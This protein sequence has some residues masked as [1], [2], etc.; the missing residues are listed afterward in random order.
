MIELADAL[1]DDI[2]Q[3]LLVGNVFEGF[4]YK[5]TCHKWW[6]GIFE[7]MER[8]AEERLAKMKE[9]QACS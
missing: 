5:M 4:F 8:K 3:H 1:A 7:K 2:D 6:I 9:R